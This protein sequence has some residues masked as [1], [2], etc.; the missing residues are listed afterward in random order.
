[1]VVIG[2]VNGKS[3][4]IFIEVKIGDRNSKE[5]LALFDT[6]AGAS[7]IGAEL[8]KSLG[9]IKRFQD[10]TTIRNASGYVMATAGKIRLT[11]EIR[12]RNYTHVLII[13]EEKGLTSQLILGW[14]FMKRYDVRFQTN[15][16]KL[17]IEGNNVTTVEIPL[18]HALHITKE[19]KTPRKEEIIEN[20]KFKCSLANATVLQG[21]NIS[22]IELETSLVE[23]DTA[24]FEPVVGNAGSHTLCPG[25]VKLESDR[26]N[27][28]SKFI[29]RYMNVTNEKIELEPRRTLG[30]VQPFNKE[31]LPDDQCNTVNTITEKKI[32]RN[33][34]IVS[35]RQ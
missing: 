19:N 13:S 4:H 35:F 31:N 26:E 9:N 6:G 18:G 20:S 21:E 16:L 7:I 22:F 24:I 3:G 28:K 12:E 25:I 33:N 30:F 14:D 8:V 10:L 23:Y 5:H 1:M 34:S 32:R 15:P 2:A 11:L 27:K 17:Y 29:I